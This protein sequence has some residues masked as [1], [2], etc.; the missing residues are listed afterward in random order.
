MPTNEFHEW[1]LSTWVPALERGDIPQGRFFLK[2]ATGEMCCLGV[3]C[4]LWPD[5]W[6]SDTVTRTSEKREVDVV[7]FVF[8][9]EDEHQELP[10]NLAR[11]WDIS[12]VGDIEII[13]E[14]LQAAWED[15]ATEIVS[16]I[17]K[18][19]PTAWMG[20]NTFPTLAWFNDQGA[21]FADIALVIR[22]A[23]EGK[24]MRFRSYG[25]V[26]R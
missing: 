15:S 9:G 23:L 16:E 3:G 10:D 18:K 12:P 8:D 20:T 24:L 25:E 5:V 7:T 22:C 19:N 1:A 2:R 21:S 17:Q 13:D 4:T 6:E 14:V 11:E 26:M